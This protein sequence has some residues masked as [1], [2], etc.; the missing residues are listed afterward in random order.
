VAA[1][2]QRA[3]A[4]EGMS[5]R[6]FALAVTCTIF[7]LANCDQPE[8]VATAGPEAT[9][10]SRPE[11]PSPTPVHPELTKALEI[12][13][14]HDFTNEDTSTFHTGAS[15]TVLIGLPKSCGAGCPQLAFFFGD[16]EFLGNDALTP[17]GAV[18]VKSQGANTIVLTYHLYEAGDAA[19]CPSGEEVDVR[20]IRDGNTVKALDPVPPDDARDI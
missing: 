13:D 12:L 2:S 9:S 19:C 5:T 3:D 7:A 17:S 6:L 14:Q 11:Q 4:T 18:G 15:F 16:G 10:T 1:E 8:P 20:F